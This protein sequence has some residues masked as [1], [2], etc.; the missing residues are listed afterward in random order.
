MVAIN[1]DA[2]LTNLVLTV[3]QDANAAV[4]TF[5]NKQI[6]MGTIFT[7]DNS[8]GQWDTVNSILGTKKTFVVMAAG[9]TENDDVQFTLRFTFKS[10]V[11][12]NPL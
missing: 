4:W 12:A 8:N 1:K 7:L 10:K 3:S 2:T 11:T 5:A 9:Q 6:T